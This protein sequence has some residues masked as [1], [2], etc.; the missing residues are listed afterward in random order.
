MP[1]QKYYFRMS[2]TIQTTASSMSIYIAC[3][4]RHLH[5]LARSRHHIRHITPHRPHPAWRYLSAIYPWPVLCLYQKRTNNPSSKKKEHYFTGEGLPSTTI[6]NRIPSLLSHLST[7][8][9]HI[10]NTP[11]RCHS[12]HTENSS[13]AWHALPKRRPRRTKSNC[14]GSTNT[15]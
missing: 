13:A 14:F 4:S 8:A 12:H 1:I 10:C 7:H 3:Y 2:F 6:W 11:H 5:G 15:S 9:E